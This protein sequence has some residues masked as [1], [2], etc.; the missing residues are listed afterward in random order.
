M[1]K[2]IK[3]KTDEELIKELSEK[4]TALSGMKFNI[5]GSKIKNVREQ[6]GT[7]KEI[8]RI[9]TELNKQNRV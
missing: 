9:L 7:K 1:A 2:E 8:A 4:R 6:R 5:A 3:T